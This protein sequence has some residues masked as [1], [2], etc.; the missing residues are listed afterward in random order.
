MTGAPQ[1]DR[2]EGFGR[3]LSINPLVAITR[4]NYVVPPPAAL[5]F[6]LTSSA[7]A[8]RSFSS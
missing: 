4:L 1:I 2:V 6:A 3:L 7:L 5:L 8:W